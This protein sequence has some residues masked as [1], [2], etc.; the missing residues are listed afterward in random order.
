MATYYKF[1]D[2]RSKSAEKFPLKI[3]VSH[4]KKTT[5]IPTGYYLT[6][7]EW[8]P[9]KKKITSKFKNSGSANAKV[10]KKYA[11]VG[12]VVESL[13]PY[14]KEL[15]ADQIKEAAEEKIT[16]EF[17]EKF[18]KEA[19]KIL[20]VALNSEK[21]DATCFYEYAGEICKQYYRNDQGGTAS[22]IEGT[23]KSLKKFTG[24]N[25]L[26][27]RQIDEAFM[28]SYEKWYVRQINDKGELNTINGF[29]FKAKD[30]RLIFNRA[31]K[32]KTVEDVTR[33]IYCFGHSGYSI[34]KE[35]TDNKNIDP[36]EIAKI[37]DLKLTPGTRLWH[38]LNYFKYYFECWGMNWADIV[39]LR[40]YQV[41][42]GRLKYR[43]RKTKWSNNAKKF[44]IGH[45][46]IAQ[47][48][49][50]Y[51]IR[52]KKPSD[53]VFPVI[54][55]IFYLNDELKDKEMEAANKKLFQ[56]KLNN[57]RSS[58]IR[59]L[60][61][62]SRNAGLKENVSIYVGRH[63]FFSIALR[64]GVSKSEISEL[65]GHSNFQV[66]EGY[67]AGFNGEQLALSANMVRSAVAKHTTATTDNGILDDKITLKG[68]GIP[69]SVID[70]LTNAWSRFSNGTRTP[71]NLLIEILQKT[72]CQ[73]GIKAQEYVNAF[74]SRQ[75]HDGVKMQK[76]D[77][78]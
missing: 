68:K 12:E 77:R 29:G 67:L 27:I 48:I 78:V 62:I 55:D 36:S 19:P 44:D 66:T 7:K 70:F 5:Y 15:N 39:F 45:S 10:E 22:C 73:D 30:I 2:D 46:P 74:L 28:V 26:P 8:D 1:F 17:Q 60:K 50:D 59:R 58:H 6:K 65:A 16:E 34:K 54:D 21:A 53:F 52:G 38:H 3:A 56:K 11:I 71:T 25:K 69:S 13:R 72:S 4:K 35:K 23:I 57:R 31:A 75:E 64:N 24:Q 42:N 51:Y 61:T 20:N 47:E 33:D 32:D 63:S 41:Q 9:E 43:R 14:W 37:Y 40:V 18:K 49:I 76:L